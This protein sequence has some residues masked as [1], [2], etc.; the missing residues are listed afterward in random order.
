[1]KKK[2]KITTN[3]QGYWTLFASEALLGSGPEAELAKEKVGRV[4]AVEG[5]LA[6]P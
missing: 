2:D 1:M 6:G 4:K 5:Y 3:L